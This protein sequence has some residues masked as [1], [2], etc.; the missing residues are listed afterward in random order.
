MRRNYLSRGLALV[1]L[2]GAFT[3]YSAATSEAAFVAWICDSPDC[4]GDTVSLVDDGDGVIN[5][6]SP[7][8][9][10]YETA[11]NISQS[12]PSISTGMDLAY[13]VTNSGNGV[14]GPI[15]L[16]AVDTDFD[17]GAVSAKGILGG[18]QPNATTTTAIICDGDANSG[19]FNPCTTE[20]SGANGLVGIELTHAISANPYAL[21]I[22]V[23][24]DTLGA[25][26]TATGN[27]SVLVPEP[28]SVALFGLG[29]A[30]FAAFRRRQ[31]VG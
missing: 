4:S 17:D 27:F 3:L 8:F 21:T 7:N 11:I 18:T 10:G 5:F 6:S 30:T 28:A 26:Q 23:G 22:G 13:V 15:Y 9:N 2:V 14:G 20:S 19:D 24:I 16:F 31:R 29:L 12:K 25:G 1:A